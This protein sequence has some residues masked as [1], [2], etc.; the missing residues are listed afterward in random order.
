MDKTNILLVDDHPESLLALEAVLDDPSYNLVKVNSG[1]E[2]LR[3]L[4]RQDFAVILIDVQM[5]G[6]D[7]FQTAQLIREREKTHD[8]PIIFTTGKL[9]DMEHISRGY[10][11]NA[12]DYL[13]KPFDPEVLKTKVAVLVELQRKTVRVREQADELREANRQ[14]E[15]EIAE[16]ERTKEEIKAVNRELETLLYVTSHDLR[17]PLRAMENFSRMVHDRYADRLDEKGQDF[18]MRVVRAAE[19]MTH[20]LNDITALSRAQ[21]MEPPTDEV[22]G[23]AIVQEVLIRLGSKIRDTEAQVQVAE[24][25]PQLRAN[26]MWATEAVYNLV[27]NA[28]KFTREGAAPEVEI[29]PYQPAEGKPGGVGI[30]V[31]DRG[32][33][34]APE[35]AERIFEL[36]QRAVGREVEGTGA[37]LA[38]VQQVARRHGGR[39]W[40]RPREGGGS[41]FIIT[42]GT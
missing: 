3:Q 33:G 18:L 8:V 12:I 35:H 14:L 38:I 2:A 10:A 28:L 5:P 40:H 37:G 4:L 13:L 32:P 9:K 29:A 22:E 16:R 23:A 36:F 11:L 7:G 27:V 25:L 41:E 39:V 26:K 19:R 42:F 15:Q 17:E 6:M 1:N 31:R 30:V 20:L 24:D 21:R 34:V